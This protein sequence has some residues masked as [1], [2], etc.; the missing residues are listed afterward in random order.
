MKFFAVSLA[1]MLAF[2]SVFARNEEKPKVLAKVTKLPV[3]LNPDFQFRKKKLYFLDPVFVQ[4]GGPSSLQAGGKQAGVSPSSKGST[5]QQD[6]S[7]SF[8]RSYRLFGAVTAL[9]RSQ[10][11]GNYFDF[12]WR[13]RRP[14]NVNVRLEYRQQRTHAHVQ[15]QE[16]SYANAH[17]TNKTEFKVIGDDFADDGRVVAWRCVLIENGVIVA[18]THSYLWD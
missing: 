9:D 11:Y 12:W 18:E 17:G 15:A 4:H 2:G 8:E 1:V 3:A 5:T 6:A 16:I 7:I 10:R 14:A 13:A